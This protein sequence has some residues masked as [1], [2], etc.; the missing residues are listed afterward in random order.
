MSDF[1]LDRP[2]HS[3]LSWDPRLYFTAIFHL[4]WFEH[5]ESLILEASIVDH[6]GELNSWI[7]SIS[8]C[9]SRPRSIIRNPYLFINSYPRARSCCY[10]FLSPPIH[11]F[12]QLNI[13]KYTVDC[14]HFK[15]QTKDSMGH[16]H[17]KIIQKFKFDCLFFSLI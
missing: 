14:F 7:S 12:S 9:Q 1:F 10:Y 11:L 15:I 13:R 2:L 4:E 17:H 3:R 5:E 16:Y 6:T 8:H